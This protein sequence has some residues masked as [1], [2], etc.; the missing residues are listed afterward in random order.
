MKQIVK[1]AQDLLPGDCLFH[2][3]KIALILSVSTPQTIS[4]YDGSQFVCIHVLIENQINE[5]N[6]YRDA[7]FYAIVEKD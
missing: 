4:I 1:I 6:P 5:W 3:E 7:R 2:I